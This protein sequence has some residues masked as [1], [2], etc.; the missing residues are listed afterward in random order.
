[1]SLDFW[2]IVDFLVTC[3]GVNGKLRFGVMS[4]A[5]GNHLWSTM[6]LNALMC[7]MSM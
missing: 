1:M 7:S 3:E 6:V 4:I 2:D 5:S